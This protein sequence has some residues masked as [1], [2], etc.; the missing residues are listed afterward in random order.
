MPG[1]D[2]M[3]YFQLYRDL[4]GYWRWRFISRAGRR[5]I[6]TSGEGYY[7]KADALDGIA[8]MQRSASGQIQEF[9]AEPDHSAAAPPAVSGAGRAV[10]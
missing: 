6:A 3:G 9:A 10:R 7:S 2:R 4:Q 8:L 5:L 1:G